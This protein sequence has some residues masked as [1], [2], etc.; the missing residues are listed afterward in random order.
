MY[1]TNDDRF[2]FIQI[3]IQRDTKNMCIRSTATLFLFKFPVYIQSITMEIL[4]V[5]VAIICEKRTN[6][7][8]VYNMYY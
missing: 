6:N 3:K 4:L 8:L 1:K 2:S 7:S 5:Y